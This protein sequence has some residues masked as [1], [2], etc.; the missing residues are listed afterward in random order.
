MCFIIR[1]Y[2]KRLN[3]KVLSAGKGIAGS[4]GRKAEGWWVEVESAHL[5]LPPKLTVAGA[6]LGAERWDTAASSRE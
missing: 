1:K 4:K 5:F 2:P 6:A 3:G